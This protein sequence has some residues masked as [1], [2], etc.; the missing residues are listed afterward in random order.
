MRKRHG[1]FLNLEF[2]FFAYATRP[3]MHIL[4]L[5]SEHYYLVIFLLNLAQFTYHVLPSI[6][7]VLLHEAQCRQVAPSQ[8]KLPEQL[9]TPPMAWTPSRF[10]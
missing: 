9:A 5:L 1:C 7:H 4:I 8:L 10:R 6:I 2:F 3:Y